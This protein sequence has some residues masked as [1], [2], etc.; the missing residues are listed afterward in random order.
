MNQI[1]SKKSLREM[2]KMF[3][4]ICY[5]K[6]TFSSI[7]L[8]L[9]KCIL[10]TWIFVLNHHQIFSERLLWYCATQQKLKFNL[11]FF[12]P[13]AEKWISMILGKIYLKANINLIWSSLKNSTGWPE[14]LVDFSPKKNISS[15]FWMIY[16]VYTIKCH[17]QCQR[18]DLLL[19]KYFEMKM[20]AG[21]ISA[22]HTS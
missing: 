19:I 3:K 8:V 17:F 11:H 14:N 2:R 12:N 7:L 13:Q 20:E 22:L 10:G 4:N 21:V 9:T 15:E 16:L 1:I 5:K 18:I 6:D